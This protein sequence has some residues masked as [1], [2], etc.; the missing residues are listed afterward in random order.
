[1]RVNLPS[2]SACILVSLCANVYSKDV[3][4]EKAYLNERKNVIVV[5]ASGKLIQ[6]TNVGKCDD[7]EISQDQIT[8]AAQCDGRDGSSVWLFRNGRAKQIKGDPYIR[9][10]RFID[11]G[12]KIAVN[13]GGLHFAGREYLYDVSTLKVLDQFSEADTPPEKVPPWAIDNQ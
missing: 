4:I 13:K 9:G 7:P 12:A 2:L 5:T 6:I 1:M 3:A 10:F 8:V 11:G